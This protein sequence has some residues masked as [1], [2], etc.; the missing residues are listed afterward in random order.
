MFAC[1]GLLLPTSK[2]QF[3]WTAKVAEDCIS[4]STTTSASK[5]LL[6]ADSREILVAG[7]VLT[8]DTEIQALARLDRLCRHEHYIT[9][10]CAW[11]AQKF[12]VLLHYGR[13]TL[14]H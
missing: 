7:K 14:L 13:P 9:I 3:F 5:L 1:A 8:Y 11:E 10:C 4:Q 2:W 12:F 6:A